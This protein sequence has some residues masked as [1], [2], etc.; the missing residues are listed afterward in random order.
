MSSVN[1]FLNDESIISQL[2][3]CKIIKKTLNTYVLKLDNVEINLNSNKY[4]SYLLLSLVQYIQTLDLKEN[5]NDVVP[6][7]FI[8]LDT[9]QVSEACEAPVKQMQTQVHAQVQL[10]VKQTQVQAQKQKYK[11]NLLH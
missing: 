2:Y 4:N 9:L 6:N 1:K 5:Q 11:P 3:K 10:P 8:C 7:K